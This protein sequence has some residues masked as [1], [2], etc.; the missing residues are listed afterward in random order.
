M[1]IRIARKEEVKI[2]QN[3]NDEVFIDNHKYD[4]D[5]KMDWAQSVTGRKY[6]TK[7]LN[8]SQAICLI[9]EEDR[10][11]MGYLVAAPKEFGYRLSKYIEIENMGVSPNYR[12]KGIGI[13]LLNKC[14]EIAKQRGF[15]K[16]YVNSYFENTKA[17]AFY[18]K[19]GLK[20]I[21]ISL[22]KNI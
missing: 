18:E 14:V 19:C 17:I 16:V 2:L 12:S 3:L 6:F 21:D 11:V 22:E 5:L 1:N 13:S 7:V 4:I 20:K 10:K 9:A 8:N 15:Q